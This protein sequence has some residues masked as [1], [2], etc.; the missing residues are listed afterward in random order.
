MAKL[1]SPRADSVKAITDWLG[2]HGL[3]LDSR[4]YSGETLTVRVPA[5]RANA[6]LAANFTAYTHHTTSATMIRTLSYSLPAYLHDH[7]AF[8]YPTTQ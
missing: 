7:V 8:V 2:K 1:A 4:S 6:M 5:A 3:S